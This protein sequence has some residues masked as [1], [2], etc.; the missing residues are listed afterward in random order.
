MEEAIQKKEFHKEFRDELSEREILGGNTDG[1]EIDRSV[2]KISALAILGTF[3]LGVFSAFLRIFLDTGDFR[4][5]I[6]SSLAALLFLII[7]V[8]Q[9]FFVK[10][11]W[12]LNLIVVIESIGLLAGFFDRI[13]LALIGSVAFAIFIFIV[14][15]WNGKKALDN[16]LK[17]DF[18]RINKIVL[19]KGIMALALFASVGYTMSIDNRFF[20]SEIFFEKSLGISSG[21]VERFYPSFSFSSTTKEMVL[22]MASEQL[23]KSPQFQILSEQAKKQI[24]NQS[25]E[26]LEIK[27]KEYLGEGF[28]FNIKF[29]KAL[30]EALKNKFDYL[31]QNIKNMILAGLGFFVFLTIVGVA[32]PIRIAVSI[33]AFLAYEA[34]LA[35][36]F[37]TIIIEGRSREIVVLK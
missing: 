2:I 9:V 17:V 28:N 32:F 5:F 33:F 24:A 30:F 37:A 31:P 22:S 13:D 34:L 11:F 4:L 36:G 6:F 1:A 35:L 19:P 12:R 23:S 27:V 21:I 10:N 29:S 20:V 14:A 25:A 26:D 7:L 8:L 3:F 15:S 16:M 18:W